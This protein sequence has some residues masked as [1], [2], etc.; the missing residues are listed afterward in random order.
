VRLFTGAAPGAAEGKEFGWHDLDHDTPKGGIGLRNLNA[1]TPE[2]ETTCHYFW[3]QAQDVQPQS[4]EFTHA[5]YDQILTAFH[6]DWEV[7]EL[8]QGNW[9]DRP[10][11]DINAD[12]GPISA[13]RLMD[14]RLAE[15]GQATAAA[16]E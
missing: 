4:G 7:F 15:E 3:S 14:R 2:T 13:R 1:I 8:Q 10:V 16:A 9:D 11:I 6:Q 5:L 12:A